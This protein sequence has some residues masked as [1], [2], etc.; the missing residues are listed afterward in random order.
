M[1]IKLETLTPV[2]IGSGIELQGNSEYLIFNEERQAVLIDTKKVLKI[3][4]EERIDQWIAVI[5]K[6]ESL[7]QLLKQ[8]KTGLTSADVAQR[9]MQIKNQIGDKKTMREQMHTGAGQP[10]LPGTSL[11]G[12]I[13]T[14]AFATL[15][16]ENK[17]LVESEANL[18]V[19]RRERRAPCGP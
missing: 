8:R 11:K 10:L 14:A 2:H 19:R 16:F 12:A 4:G 17:Q 7:L 1:T 3:I 18:G 6:Q 13:R 9:A 15:L 5:E